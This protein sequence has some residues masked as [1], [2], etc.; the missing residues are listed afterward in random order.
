MNDRYEQQ[1]REF[2]RILQQRIK[3]LDEQK[4]KVEKEKLEKLMKKVSEY[5][6]N[7]NKK[8][9]E[10]SNKPKMWRKGRIKRD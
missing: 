3:F 10:E 4:K 1:V 9:I 5:L 8:D 6:E 7:L 2:Q